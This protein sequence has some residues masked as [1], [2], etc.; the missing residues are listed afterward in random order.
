MDMAKTS[1]GHRSYRCFFTPK[2]ALGHLAPS[3]T[4]AQPFVQ[5]KAANAEA[6]FV[7]AHHVTGCPVSDVERIEHAA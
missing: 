1:A 3:D 5:L 4:G 6:A 7:S 2:D